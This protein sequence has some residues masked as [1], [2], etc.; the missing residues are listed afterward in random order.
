MIVIQK[1]VKKK[2]ISYLHDINIIVYIMGLSK[3]YM[4]F[5]I[6]FCYI[7]VY[8]SFKIIID[9]FDSS[10]LIYLNM[11][12]IYYICFLITLIL[13]LIFNYYINADEDV[14]IP[15]FIDMTKVAEPITTTTESIPE[16]EPIKM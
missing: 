8:I 4:L 13:A 11:Y 2:R 5:I 15:G 1:N 7:I 14:K 12:S 3:I 6:F 9:Y 10:K 16:A